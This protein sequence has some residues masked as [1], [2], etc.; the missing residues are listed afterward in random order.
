MARG[1]FWPALLSRTTQR[2]ALDD[3]VAEVR[4]GHSQVLVVRGEPG[5]GKTALLDYVAKNA[6]QC[7]VLRVAGVESEMQ[8]PFA[9]LHQFCAPLLDGIGQLPGPQKK[10]ISKAL[11]LRGGGVSDPFLVGLATMSLLSGRSGPPLV[12]LFDDAQWMDDESARTLAFVARR[13]AA[14]P[15]GLVFAVRDGAL[16]ELLAN[17]PELVLLGLQDNDAELLL[18]STVP[19]PLDRRVRAQLLDEARGN[20]LALL[21]LPRGQAATEM[22][23]GGWSDSTPPLRSRLEDGFRWRI[24]RLP[25]E[26]RRLLLVAAAEPTGDLLLLRRAADQLGIAAEAGTSAEE[27]GLIE[28]R[29]GVRFR[30]PLIRSVT[31]RLARL[32][33]RQA[34]HQA[35]ADATDPHLDPDRRA[36][37]RGRAAAGP[38]ELVAVE[39][40]RS[41]E[42]AR[43]HGGLAAAAAFLERAAALTPSAERRGRRAIEAAQAKFQAGAF[44]DAL[45]LLT[46]AEKAPLDSLQLAQVKLLR[47]EVAFESTHGYEALTLLL[48]AAHEMEPLNLELARDTY[49]D[50]LAAAMFA[51]RLRRGT[52]AVQV[53]A[54]ALRAPRPSNPRAGDLLLEG[55]TQYFVDGHAAAVPTVR[56][57]LHAYTTRDLA[58]AEGL[59]SMWLAEA[60]AIELWDFD[61]WRILTARH[62]KMAR[63]SGAMSALPLALNSSVLVNLMAGDLRA[64][65]SLAQETKVVSEVAGVTLEPYG[66]LSLAA[67]QG[68]QD[69]AGPLI[70]AS[71][72]A[73][74]KRG[75]GIGI[76]LNHWNRAVL[77][78]G[79]GMYTDALEAA[80]EAVAYPEEA[81][82]SKWAL[83]DLVE[84]GVRSGRSDLANRALQRI[85]DV[86]GLI[87]SEW[88]LGVE[89]CARGLVSDAEEADS[90][91]VAAIAHLERTP[92]R[93]QLARAHLLRGEFLRR[94]GRRLDARQDLRTAHHMFDEM[95]VEAF[96]ERTAL[97]LQATGEAVKA[98]SGES[99]ELLTAQETQIADYAADGLTNAQIGAKLFIS[100]RTVEWH[101]RKVF[102]KLGLNTRKGLR[103]ALPTGATS[104]TFSIQSVTPPVRPR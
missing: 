77:Y 60:M 30:H 97:E 16:R 22:T 19:G 69:V 41:A 1:D 82:A 68:R 62:L 80:R 52:N 20:P 83:V 86:A 73:I 96:A 49:L 71:L 37:H 78:N 32:Q 104:S 28:F 64:A 11:G 92:V 74:R 23:F 87:G 4:A 95:G 93:P 33:E 58:V 35:L 24:R 91:Y 47:A 70:D 48:A 40:E 29:D 67:W 57:A 61:S 3:L 13:L 31:Y 100:P 53:A 2:A 98:G 72:R 9:A 45:R 54:T 101:L 63:E 12:C 65:A 90:Y 55:I 43:T 15:V 36:W 76:M 25:R 17:L 50:T 27:A 56:R 18:D 84:A 99:P 66:A 21:E 75:E 51:G 26:S 102:V 6:T 14:E 89:A 88:V 38:D 39:L 42:R 7:R 59:H 8:L 10:A 81:G 46:S 94:Q 103:S 85:S 5:I 34:V 44:P 79:L